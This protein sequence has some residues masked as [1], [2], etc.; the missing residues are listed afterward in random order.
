MIRMVHNGPLPQHELL[1]VNERSLDIA[2]HRKNLCKGYRADLSA[3]YQ[4]ALNQNVLCDLSLL[5]VS[6]S[7]PYIFVMIRISPFF[8]KSAG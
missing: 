8:S 6:P 3:N 4:I 7:E 2:T 1:L 5:H